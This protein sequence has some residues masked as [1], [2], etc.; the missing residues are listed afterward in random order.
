MHVEAAGEEF[1]EEICG[2]HAFPIPTRNGGDDFGVGRSIPLL[3][4]SGRV[5]AEKDAGG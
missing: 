4:L 5:I 3:A 1:A 2:V